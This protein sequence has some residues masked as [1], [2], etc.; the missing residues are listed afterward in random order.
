VTAPHS[1]TPT[2]ATT[3]TLTAAAGRDALAAE[4]DTV[5]HE[6]VG[7]P[8]YGCDI[9]RENA[10]HVLHRTSRVVLADLRGPLG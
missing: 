7:S 3:A 6:Y 10:D 1:W 5:R 2:A 8:F 9:C 4:L